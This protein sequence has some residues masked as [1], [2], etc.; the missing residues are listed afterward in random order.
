METTKKPSRKSESKAS[1]EK[2]KAAY[3]E[4]VL[5]QGSRPV[6]VY[7]F[8]LDLGIKEEDFYNL[9]GSFD[10]LENHIWKGFIDKTISRL[11]ADKAF[12]SFITRE[13]ILAFYFT[14]LEELK[15]N[16][17]YV[18]FQLEHSKKFELVPEYIK[19]FKAEFESFFE[20]ELNVAKGKGEIANRPVLDKRYPQLFWLHLGFVLLFWKQDSSPG[21][22]K[23]DAAIEKSVNLAFD[24]IGKG[25]VDTAIDF[26]K[27]LYQNKI[28]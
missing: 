17:S 19:G 25:A 11:K 3:I 4:F 18:L 6:S 8:C 1:E 2:I 9:F 24:L 26:A 22:E 10:G 28:K 16:R 21:F 12:H 5:T 15:S 13:K 7:K 23:T 20:S 14:L 27:F